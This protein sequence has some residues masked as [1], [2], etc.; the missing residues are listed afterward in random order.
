MSDAQARLSRSR[1]ARAVWLNAV[2]VKWD[3]QM[4][5]FA[6]RR[7][8]PGPSTIDLSVEGGM[9]LIVSPAM[10]SCCRSKVQLVVDAGYRAVVQKQKG[11]THVIRQPQGRFRCSLDPSPHFSIEAR[12]CAYSPATHLL[13]ARPRMCHTAMEITDWVWYLASGSTV[14]CVLLRSTLRTYNIIKLCLEHHLHYDTFDPRTV[15]LDVY[16]L[17]CS[18]PAHSRF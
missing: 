12:S 15:V 4:I 9:M 17:T 16:S 3:V 8:V 2:N 13:S 6:A 10:F 5:F 1:S 14:M 18:L 7:G 11:L